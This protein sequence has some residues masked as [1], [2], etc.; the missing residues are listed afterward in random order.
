MQ[1]EKRQ[2]DSKAK[3]LS[4][5]LIIVFGVLFLIDRINDTIPNWVFSWKM[6]LI[7]I[8]LIS[9]YKH[10][11]KH[12]S[13]Y[14]LVAIGGTFLV[15]DLWPHTIQADLLFPIIIIAFGVLTL[16]KALNL[17]GKKKDPFADMNFGQS[18]DIDS[19]DYVDASAL[20]GGIN[21]TIVSKSFKGAKLSAVFGGIEVNL[22]KSDIQGSIIVH[23]TTSFG[24]TTI[25]VPSNWKVQS[26]I[27]TVFGG[28]DDNR[29]MI[30]ELNQDDSKTLILTG[31][32]YFGGVE[33][34]SY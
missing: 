22:T 34:Q 9:L 8:G 10:N 27:V 4:G 6:I 25:I 20:F 17:F 2:R 11:F 12:F 18:T 5:V 30:S 7:A 19:D 28:V 23:T 13:G 32:C 21:K 3:L 26:E 33:I 1:T 15:N 14:V 16:G 31:N 24:G 29:K